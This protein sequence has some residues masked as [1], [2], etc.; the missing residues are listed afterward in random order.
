MSMANRRRYA[1][2]GVLAIALYGA[3]AIMDGASDPPRLAPIALRSGI[4]INIPQRML[5]VMSEGGV[6]ARYPVGLGR[7]DW[8]TF[9]GPFTIEVKEIDPVWDVP[10]TIQE[11]QRRAGQPVL[12][13]VLPGPG[14]PL[15]KYWLGLSI[16][17]YGIHGT[18]APGT[19]ST[20]QTHGCVR[21][22][23]PD[24]EDLFARVEVGT[25][26]VSVYEPILIALHDGELWMEA[27]PDV[28]R[29]DRRDALGY[30]TIEAARLAP[31]RSLDESVVIRMLE[32]RAGV[33]QRIDQPSAP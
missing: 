16:T 11:E 6:V 23:A 33:P 17:G 21:M 5:F 7:P 28:Y 29:R 19:V 27:Q 9:I 25:P 31:S 3:L 20:F 18:N 10:L 14:N 4:V 2:G 32:E 24:I 22:L 1:R 12:T 26:G 15:G 30:I 8:P 13:R